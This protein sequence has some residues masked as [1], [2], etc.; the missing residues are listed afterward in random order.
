VAIE[1]PELRQR[2]RYQ[3]QD[4]ARHLEHELDHPDRPLDA[5]LRGFSLTAVCLMN[6][7]S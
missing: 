6:R 4:R 3:N 5:D 2:E 7:V 1:S